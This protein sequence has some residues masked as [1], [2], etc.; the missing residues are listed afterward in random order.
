MFPKKGLRDPFRGIGFR[1][2]GRALNGVTCRD[3]GTETTS[4]K[5]SFL[6]SSLQGQSRAVSS[7]VVC[8]DSPTVLQLHP[9][10]KAGFRR[11]QQSFQ[12]KMG[13]PAN[14]KVS[15]GKQA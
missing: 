5:H 7:E 14:L 12:N 15:R 11:K 4:L 8:D 1:M 2:G 3:S 13:G 6:G 9:P 10:S